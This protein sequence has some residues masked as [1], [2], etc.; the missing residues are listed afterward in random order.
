MTAQFKMKDIGE[1]H[2]CLGV[3]VEHDEQQKCVQIHQKQYILNMLQKYGLS[4]AKTVSTPA[5]LSVRLQ[6]N[7][8]VSKLVNPIQ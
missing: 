4:E 8:G 3:T 5:D 2:Y 7:D 1:L 6:K